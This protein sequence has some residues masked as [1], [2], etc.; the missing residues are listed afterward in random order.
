VSFT[1]PPDF[2]GGASTSGHQTEG[3]N[4]SS[5]W[6]VLE[7][8][9]GRNGVPPADLALTERLIEAHR[10]ARATL[11]RNNRRVHWPR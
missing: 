6:R 5:D 11:R 3:G 1:V 7:N 10:A 2:L 4:V 9:P 8:A